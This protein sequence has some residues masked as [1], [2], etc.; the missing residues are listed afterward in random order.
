MH[1]G[2]NREHCTI[3]EDSKMDCNFFSERSVSSEQ[4]GPCRGFLQSWQINGRKEASR[5][6]RKEAAEKPLEQA[7]FN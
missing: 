5:T 7:W 4:T 3:K 6:V 2:K 1:K